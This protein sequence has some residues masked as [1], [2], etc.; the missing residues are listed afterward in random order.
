M[1]VC[2]AALRCDHRS[3]T[4]LP[5]TLNSW[6]GFQVLLSRSYPALFG[7]SRASTHFSCLLAG[8]HLSTLKSSLMNSA[9]RSSKLIDSKKIFHLHNVVWISRSWISVSQRGVR[10]DFAAQ[11]QRVHLFQ[12]YVTFKAESNSVSVRGQNKMG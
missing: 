9:G 6:F 10:F 12:I 3:P 5:P 1:H 7:M 4:H 8:P 2:S 11:E